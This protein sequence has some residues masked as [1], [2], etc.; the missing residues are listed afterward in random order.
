[1]IKGDPLISIIV[2]VYNTEKFLLSCIESILN[3]DYKNIEV[4]LVNDGSTDN[5]S[6][7][8]KKYARI[9]KRVSMIE[10]KNAGVSAARNTGL[11]VARGDYIGFVDSDD[12]I[13]QNMYSNLLERIEFDKSDICVLA[14]YT[15]RPFKWGRIGKRV[16]DKN[17]AIKRLFL[18][19]FPTSVWAYL[20]RREIIDQI[21]LNEDIHFFEDFEFNYRILKRCNKISL[22][23]EY[24]YEYRINDYSINMSCPIEK[25]LSSLIIYDQIRKD[26][27]DKK[28]GSNLYKYSILAR[29]HLLLSILSS[30]AKLPKK[31]IHSKKEYELKIKNEARKMICDAFLSSYVPLLYKIAVIFSGL[32]PL[33]IAKIIQLKY[34]LRKIIN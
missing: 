29:V 23:N 33:V 30:Y 6:L 16:I 17:E 13:M 31:E 2:P 3:Q 9:D 21:Y 7:I 24:L 22:C 32:S 27:K 4:I 28:I 25:K 11:F 10:K 1:M 14:K 5:S 18:L 8:C 26:Y 20:Y 15:I 19:E 34:K 12:K